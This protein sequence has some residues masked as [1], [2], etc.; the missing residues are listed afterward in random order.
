MNPRFV[1]PAVLGLGCALGALL[2]CSGP[3]PGFLEFAERRTTIDPG[4][5]SGAPSPSSSAAVPDASAPVDAGRTDAGAADPVFGTTTFAYTNPG[6]TANG[7]NAAHAGT[8]EG[9]DCVVAGC[10]G[11][12]SADPWLFGGTVYNAAQGGQ[13]VAQAEVRVVDATGTE[14]AKAYTDANGNF[15]FQKGALNMPVGGRVGVRT[16]TAVK[17]MATP[18]QAAQPGAGGGCNNAGC[19]GATMRVYVN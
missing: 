1:L 8:V 7:A 13:T 10:H 14:V 19:H 2:A 15:W 6:V 3:D 11:N 12:G 9:K 17:R 18:L 5:S 16:A 4:P